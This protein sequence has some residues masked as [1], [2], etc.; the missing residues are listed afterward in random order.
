MPFDLKNAPSEFQ[1]IIN[2]NFNSY[3]SFCIVYIDD[4]LIFSQDIDQHWK[5]LKTF[6]FMTGQNGLTISAKKIKLFQFLGFKI[7]QG[8]LAPINRI[9]SFA[10]KF[11]DELRDKK[12]LQRFLRCLNYVSDFYKNLVVNRKLLTDRL[13]KN[14]SNIPK[15]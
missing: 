3:T 4:V 13:K 6:L 2:E 9:I 7:N 14:L 5:H 11:P 10:E 8:T 1:K 15:W 12:Q